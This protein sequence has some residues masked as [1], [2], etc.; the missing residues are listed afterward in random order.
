ME[1][2]KSLVAVAV[3]AASS[4]AAADWNYGIGTGVFGLNIDGDTAF[5]TVNGTVDVDNDL[6]T[7]D[8]SDLVESM[9]GLN[10]YATDGV[11]TISAS[12]GFLELEDTL[13]G[14]GLGL[15][16]GA[17]VDAN[18]E[19][20]LGEFAVSYNFYREGRTALGVLGGVRYFE[21]N[22]DFV[23][24]TDP[25]LTVREVDEDWTDAVLGVTHGYAINRDLRWSNRASYSFGSS[26]GTFLINS[27]LRYQ[28]A[29]HFA[30]TIYA[31]FE[32]LEFEEGNR[33]SVDFYDYDNDE[34][35]VGLLLQVTW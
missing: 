5:G 12:Y 30:G 24:I 35:G 14:T 9:I 10:G 18:W 7:G 4:G 11:W 32:T 20:T 29:Q 6:D 19:R 31:Q 16:G 8:I 22:Y 23:V 13:S 2:R 3:M 15:A 26:E 25:N 34:F 33:G 28:F 17:L 1:F 27:A 21:H